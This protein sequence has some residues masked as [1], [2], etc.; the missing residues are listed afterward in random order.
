MDRVEHTHSLTQATL[1]AGL[2]ARSPLSLSRVEHCLREPVATTVA[3]SRL[4][5]VGWDEKSWLLASGNSLSSDIE[6]IVWAVTPHEQI[7]ES[8]TSCRYMGDGERS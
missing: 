2:P 4:A 1:G 7:T 6:D 3:S 5:T 8:V